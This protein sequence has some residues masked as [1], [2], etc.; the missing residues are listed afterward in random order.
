MSTAPTRPG[1]E[2]PR[3][4]ITNQH[5]DT[6]HV[7]CPLDGEAYKMTAEWRTIYNEHRPYEALEGA[8]P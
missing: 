2:K 6:L 7:N 3:V 5:Q 8:A 1:R 4:L